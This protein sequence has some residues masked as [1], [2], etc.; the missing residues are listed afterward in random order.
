MLRDDRSSGE[1]GRSA[2]ATCSA[3]PSSPGDTVRYTA[4]VSPLPDGGTVAFTDEGNP[5]PDQMMAKIFEPMVRGASE[6]SS[7]RSVGLGLFIVRAIAA[8]HHG[9]VKVRSTAE[10]GTVNWKTPLLPFNSRSSRCEPKYGVSIRFE[11][12]FNSTSM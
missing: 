10:A 8:A 7:A 9:E 3:N 6:N 12:Y 11:T 5:I 2:P 1:G 4:T